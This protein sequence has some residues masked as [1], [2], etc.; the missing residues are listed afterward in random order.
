MGQV[1]SFI[2]DG[3]VLRYGIRHTKTLF[4]SWDFIATGLQTA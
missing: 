4:A 1:I 2:T 3:Y